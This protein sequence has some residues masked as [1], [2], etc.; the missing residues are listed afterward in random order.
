MVMMHEKFTI[1]EETLYISNVLWLRSV[2]SIGIHDTSGPFQSF[3]A[4]TLFIIG[5]WFIR[6]PRLRFAEFFVAK[7]EKYLLLAPIKYT[8]WIFT[9]RKATVSTCLWNI[10]KILDTFF[11]F[12]RNQ[13]SHQRS[14][15]HCH[16][17]WI[18]MCHFDSSA[19]RRPLFVSMHE[20]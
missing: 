5:I 19:E 18:C 8:K 16:Q 2:F 12:C 7:T 6:I 15:I 13:S 17:K 11:N 20:S 3:R 4:Y 1:K 14:L 9:S 10:S